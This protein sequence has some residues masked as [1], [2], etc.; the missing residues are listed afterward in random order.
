MGGAMNLKGGKRLTRGAWRAA[1]LLMALAILAPGPQSAAL[2]DTGA[3]AIAIAAPIMG[4]VGCAAIGYGMWLN[5]PG[6]PDQ[7]PKIP[8]ELY[9]GVFLGGSLVGPGADNWN[10]R[11]AGGTPNLSNINY[12]PAVVGGVKIGWFTPWWPNIGIEAETN[13]TRHDIAQQTVNA[14]PAII[15]NPTVS[16]QQK[17]NVWTMALKL[18]FRYG[19][20]KDQEVPFG[21]LQPYLGIGP[22]AVIIYGQN[23]SAKNLSLEVQAGVRYMALKNVSIFTEYKYSQQWDV[24][25]E[26]QQVFTPG[27]VPL[28]LGRTNFDFDTHKFVLGVAYHW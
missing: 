20:F 10:F 2:A 27:G 15:F 1:A 13:F 17:F 28:A 22:G 16:I 12:Q 24:E 5:R 6:S 21:R 8:G 11:Y 4:V 19:F 25:L 26:A 23:D 7:P 18:M 3:T 9:T 14:S